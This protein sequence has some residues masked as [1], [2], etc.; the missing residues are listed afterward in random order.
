MLF[1][2][3]VSSNSYSNFDAFQCPLM[4]LLAMWST[5]FA[6]FPFVSAIEGTAGTVFYAIWVFA[7]FSMLS[8][9]FV[10]IPGAC[11]RI[12][13]A[14]NMATIYGLVYAATVSPLS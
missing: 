10:I 11:T 1:S 6:T 14:G 4:L 12:F 5:L 2:R 7:I 13:G 9:H 3:P 8:G